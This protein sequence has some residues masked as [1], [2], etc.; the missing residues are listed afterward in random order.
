MD[1]LT[2]VA[3]SMLGVSRLRAAS[4]FKAV[5]HLDD[6]RDVAA[7]SRS[8][9]LRHRRRGVAPV[10]SAG[11]AN[12]GSTPCAPAARPGWSQSRFSSDRY[13]ALIACIPDPPP[14]LWCAG[15]STRLSRPGVA[16]V[17]S[18]AATPYALQVGA[19]LGAELADRRS[20][21]RERPCA[22]ESTR[23]LIEDAWTPAGRP[24]RCSARASIASIRASMPTSPQVSR[25]KVLGE[26]ARTRSGAASGALSPAQPDHQRDL[27][28]GRCRRSLRE[29]RLP[30]YR[31]MR[32]GSGARRHGG[33][34]QRTV[35]PQPR[36]ARPF[37]GRSKGRRDCGR[38]S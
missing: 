2:A 7:G 1:L 12:G 26:R 23:Q 32:P 35:G 19:R 30:H 8:R 33:A 21:R 5:Q 6:P 25:N 4:A 18:R 14:V 27:P 24:W 17:G 38:Y 9:R 22:G 3:V 34:R 11:P 13:P 37:E 28:G 10:V 36:L 20:R 15:I 16:I 31:P 29:E